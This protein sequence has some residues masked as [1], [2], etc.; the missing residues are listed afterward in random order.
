MLLVV[1]TLVASR[2]W[3]ELIIAIS[4]RGYVLLV[5]ALWQRQR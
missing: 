2:D 4:T 3:V 5:C 1:K